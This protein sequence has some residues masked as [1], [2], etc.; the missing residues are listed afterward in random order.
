MVLLLLPVAGAPLYVFLHQNHRRQSR[1]FQRKSLIDAQLR[2]V[3]KVASR[4][5]TLIR[6]H[7]EVPKEYCG[8]ARMVSKEDPNSVITNGNEIRLFIDGKDMFQ[9][10]QKD[11]RAARHHI[12]FQYYL[13]KD[14]PLGQEILRILADKA[15]EGVEVRVLL[16][17]L[18][19]RGMGSLSSLLRENGVHLVFFYPGIYHYNYRNHRKIVVIDGT[20]GYCGGYN[21]AEEYVGKGPLGYW[22]DT[23]IRIKGPE[24]YELQLRFIQDW[25]YSSR[26]QIAFKSSYFPIMEPKGESAV[27]EVSSGPDTEHE[28]IKEAYLKMISLANESCYIQTPYFIPDSSLMETLNIAAASG[29]DVRL[30]IPNKPDHP[31]VYWATQSFCADLMESGVRIFLYEQGFLHAKTIVVDGK[32]GSIGSANFDIRS[33]RL[34]FETNVIVYDTRVAAEMKDIFLQDLFRCSEL[35]PARYGARD[36]IVRIKEPFARLV[37]PLV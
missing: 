14:D 28:R 12:H 2:K 24:V 34:N 36:L 26:E 17:S 16:D 15:K 8:L 3:Y 37:S 31:F 27:Q 29:V 22:R 11:L 30:M 19:S 10:L 13:V 35:T 21:V 20:V 23:E 32:I 9:S 1:K 7:P 4:E 18:G 25:N 6:P 33:F 5:G